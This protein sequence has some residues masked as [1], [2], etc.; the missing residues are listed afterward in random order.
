MVEPQRL[1]I[2]IFNNITTQCEIQYKD[3]YYINLFIFITNISA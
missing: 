2:R 1:E 3:S